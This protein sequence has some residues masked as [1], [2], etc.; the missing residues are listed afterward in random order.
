MGKGLLLLADNVFKVNNIVSILSIG[1]EYCICNYE[2]GQTGVMCKQ[3]CYNNQLVIMRNDEYVFVYDSCGILKAQISMLNGATDDFINKIID[4]IDL[5]RINEMIHRSDGTDIFIANNKVSDN[6]NMI[7]LDLNVTYMESIN[8]LVDTE[9]NKVLRV[10]LGKADVRMRSVDYATLAIKNTLGGS[11]STLEII[12]LADGEKMFTARYEAYPTDSDTN[13]WCIDGKFYRIENDKLVSLIRDDIYS[14]YDCQL[15]LEA[16]YII[17]CY[18]YQGDVKE[19]DQRRVRMF[20]DNTLL[21]GKGDVVCE[22]SYIIDI[23]MLATIICNKN[24]HNG[25]YNICISI[26]DR[27]YTVPSER[28]IA[29]YL[30][31]TLGYKKEPIKSKVM[32]QVIEFN[33][34]LKVAVKNMWEIY[35]LTS[36]GICTC[37]NWLGNNFKYLDTEVNMDEYLKLIDVEEDRESGAL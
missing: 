2:T 19:V 28:D 21:D 31:S 24:E 23:D 11:R 13:S 26:P 14:K 32:E 27:C 35:I 17:N 22:N 3:Y 9:N 4:C 8:I 30:N 34:V 7:T 15:Y 6:I 18:S 10:I 33:D 1:E 36:D 20:K 25:A 37:V 29:D 16:G 5:K 12:R